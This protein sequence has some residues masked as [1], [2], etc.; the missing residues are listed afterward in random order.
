[1]ICPRALVSVSMSGAVPVTCTRSLTGP[2]LIDASIRSLD[3]TCT[4]TF[5]IIAIANPGFS[6]VNR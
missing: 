2:T 4:V 6:T 1:M 5:S 3:P